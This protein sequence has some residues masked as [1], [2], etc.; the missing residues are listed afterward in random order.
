MIA[1]YH[2]HTFRCGHASGTEREYIER[3]IENGI[4]IMGFSD[5]IP[6]RFPDGTESGFRVPTESAEEYV[7]ALRGLKEEYKNDIEIHIGFESEYYPLYYG[8]MLANAVAWGAEYLILGQHFIGNEHPHGMYCGSR[9]NTSENLREYAGTVVEAIKTGSFSYVAHPDVFFFGGS[10]EEYVE[11]MRKICVA[12]R[13]F[14][15]PL[16]INLL[17]IRDNRHYPNELFWELAGQEGC[18]AVLGFDAHD[19]PSAFDGG[20]VPRALELAAENGI[21]VAERI[22][23][24]S[25][26]SIH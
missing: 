13:Q 14:G 1:N 6:F 22:T 10:R 21:E 24:R 26:G 15:V 2:T 12:S 16:E 23:L 20:S 9:Q 18:T 4:K 8:E 11:E 7:S 19:V 3:A 5:H 17:G 25:L